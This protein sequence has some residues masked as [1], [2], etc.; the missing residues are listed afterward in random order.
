MI[1]RLSASEVSNPLDLGLRLRY[2]S[3]NGVW[4][5]VPSQIQANKPTSQ[6]ANKPTSQQANKPTS[7]QANKPTSQ[8]AKSISAVGV[9]FPV[10]LGC[11]S[12]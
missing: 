7:Q 1:E 4:V 5:F 2:F 8:Q 3:P 6:Q 11:D 12:N 10:A 9:A